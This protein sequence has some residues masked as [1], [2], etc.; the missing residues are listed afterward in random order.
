IPLERLG[1]PQDIAGMVAF[2]ASDHAAY[3]TGQTLVVDGGMVM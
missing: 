3:I 1:T 2:L